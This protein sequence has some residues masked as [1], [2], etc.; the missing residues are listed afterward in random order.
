MGRFAHL[1][2]G[3]QVDL[4]ALGGVE[5]VEGGDRNVDQIANAVAVHD[6]PVGKGFDDFSSEAGDHEPFIVKSGL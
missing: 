5:V 6:Q 2:V 1:Q 4:H 3:A